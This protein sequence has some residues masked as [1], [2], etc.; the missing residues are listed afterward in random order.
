[1]LTFMRSVRSLMDL[2]YHFN[3]V[4]FNLFSFQLPH[5]LSIS[6]QRSLA[7]GPLNEL[8]SHEFEETTFVLSVSNLETESIKLV[9]TRT[10][11]TKQ[12]EVASKLYTLKKKTH[13]II[14]TNKDGLP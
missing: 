7:F 10:K 2:K 5:G 11:F 3:F 9:L 12:K 14:L 6:F 4:C 8:T 1:M 13:Q